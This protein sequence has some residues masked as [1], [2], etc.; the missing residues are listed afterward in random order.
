MGCSDDGSGNVLNTVGERLPPPENA[1]KLCG[2][3]GRAYL[4]EVMFDYDD[5]YFATA[6]V[7]SF[8]ANQYGILIWPVTCRNGCMTTTARLVALV[9]RKSTR[10][11]RNSA[12]SIPSGAPAGHGAITRC[13]CRSGLWEE[14]RDDVD[15]A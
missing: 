6:A 14:P 7:A 8:Q 15:S 13:V 5:G 1:G 12:S 3:Y 11:D 9:A 2:H 10:R 4:G